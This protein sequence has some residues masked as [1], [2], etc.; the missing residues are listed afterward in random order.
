YAARGAPR[1]HADNPSLDAARGQ[2]LNVPDPYGTRRRFRS[3]PSTPEKEY[4]GSHDER[5]QR[6]GSPHEGRPRGRRR[7]DHGDLLHR[8]SK[9]T[10]GLPR[11]RRGRSRR[12]RELR[13]GRVPPLPWAAPQPEGDRGQPEGAVL[14]REPQAPPPARTARAP[15]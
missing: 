7:L 9:G 6:G 3:A 4:R 14:D 1:R 5:S 13:G 12:A 8:W 10:A 2:A 15:P 11:L